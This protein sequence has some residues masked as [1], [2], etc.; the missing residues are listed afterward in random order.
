MVK[1]ESIFASYQLIP[2]RFLFF[3]VF[4]SALLNLPGVTN[5]NTQISEDITHPARGQIRVPEHLRALG[6]RLELRL[7]ALPQPTPLS[8]APSAGILT[9]AP[10]QGG[11]GALHPFT[12]HTPLPLARCWCCWR[13]YKCTNPQTATLT[14]FGG[15]LEAPLS[16]FCP[17]QTFPSS[18][19]HLL[20]PRALTPEIG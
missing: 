18:A 6:G 14:C 15:K 12:A 17:S 8:P 7:V 1:P 3:C 9:A 11:R 20:K 4:L 13:V 2:L 16:S 10:V 5:Q 19:H